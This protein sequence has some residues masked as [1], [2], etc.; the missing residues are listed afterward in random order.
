MHPSVHRGCVH[1]LCCVR[2]CS[3]DGA[4]VSG[5]FCISLV[6]IKLVRQTRLGLG[7]FAIGIF[8]AR[9]GCA[10]AVGIVVVGRGSKEE[11][12]ICRWG[13]RIVRKS[14]IIKSLTSTP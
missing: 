2:D 6:R 12:S 1:T 3:G 9:A 5:G 11:E 13:G 4:E 8:G 7:E 10:D 14:A